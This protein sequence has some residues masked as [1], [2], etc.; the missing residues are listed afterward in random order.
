MKT[1]KTTPGRKRSQST[2]SSTSS[3]I[4]TDEMKGI[5]ERLRMEKH[6]STTKQ[7][8]YTVWKLFSKFNLCLD[9]KPTSWED[10]IVLFIGYLVDCN[11]QSS[12]V[13]SYLSAIR[14]VLKDDGIKLDEDLFLVSSLTQPCKYRKDRIRTRLP[15][16]KGM[17][18]MLLCETE[19]YYNERNQPYLKDLYRAIFSTMYFGLLQISEVAC[20]HAV[21]A[22]DVNIGY[23]K[24][25][26]LFI[27]R[28]SKTHWQ[29]PRPCCDIGQFDIFSRIELRVK[30]TLELIPSIFLSSKRLITRMTFNSF[31]SCLMSK[32]SMEITINTS[33]WH[34]RAK[35]WNGNSHVSLISWHVLTSL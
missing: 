8:Y 20:Q 27:L 18:I 30:V 1:N 14:A 34:E 15:L 6:R 11:K 13:K 3:H 25:K 5:I 23:N 17:L 22:R 32:E 9:V 7:M 2:S 12:T 10:R 16:Q 33:K 31:L 19:N 35:Q 21:L 28:S 24:K 4:S 26:M 29:G